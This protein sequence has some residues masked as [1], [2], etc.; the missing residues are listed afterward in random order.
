MQ[1]QIV[2]DAAAAASLA[3][4]SI[5]RRLRD[6]VRRRGRASVAFSGGSTPALMLDQLSTLDVPWR[7]VDV[8]QVDERIAPDG[9]PDRNAGQLHD[10]L[11]AR[12]GLR[13]AQV[14]LMPVTVARLPAAAARYADRLSSHL[15]FDVVH[16]GLGDDGHTASWPPGDAVVGSTASVDLCGT[17]NGRVR[18]T[19]TPGPV[20]GARYRLVL[21]A[22]ASKAPMVARWLE[23]DRSLP[24]ARVRR[25]GTVL[26][27]DRA[28]AADW[29]S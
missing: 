10:H 6:A 22:G 11:V 1:V 26:V 29:V 7:Q 19:L 2:D 9:D 4:A 20:N 3:A 13:A 15:P 8:F 23:G 5:A 18:M 12:V 25:T 16:L 21:T 17:F 14:H 27:V 24:I 28:A